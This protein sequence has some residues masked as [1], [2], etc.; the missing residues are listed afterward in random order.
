M[1]VNH[2]TMLEYKHLF[3]ELT[4]DKSAEILTL[5]KGI[6]FE[7]AFPIIARLNY[8]VRKGSLKNYE[9]ELVFWFG[10]NSV[11]VSKYKKC[12]EVGYNANEHASLRLLNIWSNLSLLQRFLQVYQDSHKTEWQVDDFQTTHDRLF[13]AYLLINEEYVANFNSQ[14][15]FASIPENFGLIKRMGFT[16]AVMLLPYHDLNHVDPADAMIAQ[17][18][19][20]V[21]FLQ[22]FEIALP[23]ALEKF[24]ESYGMQ[25]WRDYMKSIFPIVGHALQ[26]NKEGLGYLTINEQDPNSDSIRKILG[27]IAIEESND[28]FSQYD[29]ILPRS[30]PLMQINTDKYLVIDNLLV[31]NKLYNSLFFEFKEIL[32]K[33]PHI[34]GKVDFKSYLN[35]HFSESFLAKQVLDVVFNELQY[36]KFSG[37]DIRKVHAPKFDAEPDYYAR[38][39]DELFLFELKD[40]LINGGT[41]QSFN[42][43][44]LEEELKTKLWFKTVNKKGE[45][46]ET[47]KA[48]RQL[49]NNIHRVAANSLPFDKD[50]E[51]K[52]LTIFPVLLYIDQSLSTP[53]INEVIQEWF[54][55]ELNN[56]PELKK[57]RDRISIM[58][59]T[60]IDLDTLIVFQDEFKVGKFKLED[61]IPRFW[62]YKQ[63]LLAIGRQSVTQAIYDSNLSFGAFVRLHRKKRNAPELFMSFGKLIFDEKYQ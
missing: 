19:K 42:F 38:N 23:E 51:N 26:N 33:N 10:S 56:D 7:I 22:F 2:V 58:P 6:N 9:D 44:K 48:I 11:L 50:L 24:L 4:G 37:E 61:F 49:L 39:N 40:T 59:L 1:K 41:K 14:K 18:I 45:A 55:T 32:K 25:T 52:S 35:D 27:N 60:M 54:S 63:G 29:F 17:F 28:D 31:Y 20:A 30:K 16:L 15:I 8:I 47:P 36:L 5:L 3:E 34:L 43:E 13:K 62:A 53:G 46:I 21:Y 12:I 57:I